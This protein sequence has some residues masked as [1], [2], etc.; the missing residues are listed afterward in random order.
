MAKGRRLGTATWNNS[1][2]ILMEIGIANSFFLPLSLRPLDQ[3]TDKWNM[4]GALC[5]YIFLD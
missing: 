2:K 3:N 4:C 1:P 5:L